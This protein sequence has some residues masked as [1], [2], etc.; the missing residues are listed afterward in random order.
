MTKAIKDCLQWSGFSG[1]DGENMD[2]KFVWVQMD[3]CVA[4]FTLLRIYWFLPQ[5]TV[6]GV[7][8]APHVTFDRSII[9][10]AWASFALHVSAITFRNSTKEENKIRMLRKTAL[11]RMLNG[12]SSSPLPLGWT[13]THH[14]LGDW[15]ST[16]GSRN[17]FH[18]QIKYKGQ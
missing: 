18:E 6:H 15:P 14:P 4:R 10:C 5:D 11:L 8:T 13:Q 16:S 7:P 1:W 9:A 17:N 12:L 2:I 3:T